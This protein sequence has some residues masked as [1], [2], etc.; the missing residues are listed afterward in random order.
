MVPLAVDFKVNGA[1]PDTDTELKLSKAQPET[2]LKIEPDFSLNW[3]CVAEVEGILKY[4]FKYTYLR[5]PHPEGIRQGLADVHSKKAKITRILQLCFKIKQVQKPSRLLVLNNAKDYRG[6]PI[7]EKQL[8]KAFDVWYVANDI[9]EQY[10]SCLVFP[11]VP[12]DVIFESVN[13]SYISLKKVDNSVL[14]DENSFTEIVPLGV[15]PY[16]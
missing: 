10:L 7:A 8:L 14:V 3:T 9:V 2:F 1:S 16:N 6:T 11:L 12:K 5:Q 4:C 13:I 15:D